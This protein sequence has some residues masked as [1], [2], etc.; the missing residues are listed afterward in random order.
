MLYTYDPTC[1]V[2]GLRNQTVQE[3]GLDI[4]VLFNS[5]SAQVT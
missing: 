3:F 1:E 5:G 2:Q 4:D